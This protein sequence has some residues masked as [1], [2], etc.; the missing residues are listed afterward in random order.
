MVD[1]PPMPAPPNS[2]STSTLTASASNRPAIAIIANAPTPY[3]LAL[4]L[5]IAREIPQVQLWSLF[6]HQTSNANWT[7]DAPAEIGPVLFGQGEA[8]GDQDKLGGAWREWQR[9][10]RV[11]RALA[12]HEVRFVVMMGYNDP[13]RWR[14]MR[15]CRATGIPCFLFGDSNIR[16]DLATGVKAWLKRLVVRRI[17]SWCDG[18]LVCGSLGRDYFLRYGARHDRIFFFPY[19]P[20][21][22]LLKTVSPDQV[23]AVRVRFKLPMDRR[24]LVYSGRL[25]PVKRVDLLIEAFIQLAPQRPAWDLVV[26]GDGPLRQTLQQRVPAALRQRVVWAGFIDDQPTVS[27][28]YRTCQVL[29]LPSDFEPWALVINE[30]AAAGMAIVASD[31]VGAAAELVR[32]GVNGRIFPAGDAAALLRCLLE[33]ADQD[34][35]ATMGAA[36]EAVL[37]DWIARGDPVQGLRQAM[38]LA[39]VLR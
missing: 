39:G 31:I 20:D 24:R 14:V 33:V 12:E 5:R 34:R 25:S 13:G 4:H 38:Q 17:V 18:V 27:A 8:S 6:T 26:V 16:G 35:A 37:A 11:I 36:S 2:T 10:G 7:L 32:D 3:R 30:A 1:H 22:A 23:A 29:V 9:G 15:W 19:E 28:I 21:Y